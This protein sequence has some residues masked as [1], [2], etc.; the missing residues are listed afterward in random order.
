MMMKMKILKNFAIYFVKKI[1]IQFIIK[2]KRKNNYSQGLK[3]QILI[4]LNTLCISYETNIVNSLTN[5]SGYIVS[6]FP[7][8][9]TLLR[10]MLD[11][12]GQFK[13]RYPPSTEMQTAQ[14]WNGLE[15]RRTP[16][17]NT[18]PRFAS[19]LSSTLSCIRALSNIAM[20]P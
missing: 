1:T 15:S 19:W 3:N 13:V 18:L 5:G 12:H 14:L 9:A 2:F 7:F 20:F 16:S 8:L 11:A 6:S 17:N 10:C 4:S